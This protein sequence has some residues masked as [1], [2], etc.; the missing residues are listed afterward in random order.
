MKYVASHKCQAGSDSVT[1]LSN[2]IRFGS[3]E[4][5]MHYFRKKDDERSPILSFPEK[6]KGYLI[7]AK[8]NGTSFVYGIREEK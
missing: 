7:I 1:V 4:H 3:I 2:P 8:I 5:V 6:G